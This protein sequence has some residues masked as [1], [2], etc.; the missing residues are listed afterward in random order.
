[1]AP[2]VT[3]IPPPVIP[4]HPKL[5][6]QAPPGIQTNGAINSSTASPSPSMTTKKPPTSAGVNGAT[7]QAA[8][9]ANRARQPS[10]QLSARNAKG[11]AG[12]PSATLVVDTVVPEVID[13]PPYSMLHEAISLIYATC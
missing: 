1:M 9:P 4:P 8:R 12:L 5:K 13:P 7:G 11:S 2:V 3:A 6:R 10:T